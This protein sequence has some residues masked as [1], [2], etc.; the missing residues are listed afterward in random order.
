MERDSDCDETN[1]EWPSACAVHLLPVRA[2]ETAA[3][4][5]PAMRYWTLFTLRMMACAGLSVALILWVAG[6]WGPT[7]GGAAIGVAHVHLG[8][9][10]LANA[11]IWV[12]VGR[13]HAFDKSVPDVLHLLHK[14]AADFNILGIM[15]RYRDMTRR[16]FVRV[17]HWLI[18]L[19][20]FIATVAT[21]RRRNHSA[22]QTPDAND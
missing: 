20:F 16:G 6:Q 8:T 2:F 18:C 1:I 5:D 21:S 10:K 13:S 7:H 22:A 3:R 17:D 4:Q 14:Q 12:P 15:F 11:V 9:N 19:S